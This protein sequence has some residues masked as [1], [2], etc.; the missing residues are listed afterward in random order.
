LTFSFSAIIKEQ[1]YFSKIE[2]GIKMKRRMILVPAVFFLCLSVFAGGGE[3][4]KIRTEDIFKFKEVSQ[5]TF[6]P[7]GRWIAY[8]VTTRDLDKNSSNSDIWMIPSQGGMPIRLTNHE[9]SDGSPDWSPDGKYLAFISGRNEKSQI[10]LFDAQGGEPYQLTKIGNGVNSF[11]WSPDSLNIAFLAKDPEP[12]EEGEKDKEAKKKSDVIVVNRLQ[13]KRDRVGYLDDKRNHIWLISVKGS[14]PK[15]LTDGPY[16]EQ[17]IGFSP[18]GKEILF[19][20]NRT[21]NPDGN[22]NTDIWA[23]DVEKGKIRQL[24]TDAKADS[25]PS[26]SGNGQ[27]IAYLKSTGSPY[28]TTFLWSISA[29]GTGPKYLTAKLD[30]N[31]RGRPIWSKD[32]KFVYFVLEDSGNVH[33]CRIPSSGGEIERVIG[34]ERTVGNPILSPDGQYLA[35]TMGD[36]LSPAELFISRTDGT[37]LQK[38]TSLNTELLAELKLSQPENI[39]YKSFDGQEIEAWVM[40]PADLEP[41]KKYPM[42]VRPHGGPNSQYSTSFNSD[43]QL[44]AAEGYVV[45][46]P[47]P[48]G[49]SGYGEPFGRAIWADWGNKDLKDVMAGV[50][51]VVK[52]GYVDPQKLGIF[53]WSY[54]G[55]MTNYAITRTNRFKAAVSGASESDYF[56]CYGYDDLHLLWEEELGLPWDNFELYRK[57][58]PIIDVKKV[59]TP[60][61]FMCGQFDYRCPL[62]Q[63]E[64]MYLSLKRLGLETELIVYPGESHG[65]SRLDHQLDRTTRV[66]QWFNKY[67]K[68]DN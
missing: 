58:S 13:H 1:K 12:K 4:R 25:N 44:L 11:V 30:R 61:V 7:D 18:D 9:K 14:E 23:V 24:T 26:W 27:Y 38:L 43:F 31:V 5:P 32:N 20:S 62:P 41:G 34:G 16:D 33:L 56:S 19:E 35:F 40:I 2:E 60:T 10:W 42:I 8:V 67:L 45:L 29:D 50:D 63:S 36:L 48:R 46:Y 51:Y 28:G 47:N 65:I 66:I 55:I 68:S 39:H 17:N 53:G 21:Q 57:I 52:Q 37:G 64:Q 59:K 15:K 3:K 22:R 6:S 54:G 49:S